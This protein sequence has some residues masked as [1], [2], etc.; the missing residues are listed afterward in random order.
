MRSRSSTN[1]LLKLIDD[2]NL[3]RE[4]FVFFPESF[5]K[6]FF[7]KRNVKGYGYLFEDKNID[8]VTRVLGGKAGAELYLFINSFKSSALLSG[9]NNYSLVK[10]LYDLQKDIFGVFKDF[11]LKKVLENNAKDKIILSD[12][13]ISDYDLFALRTVKNHAEGYAS[14]WGKKRFSCSKHIKLYDL[15]LDAPV[16]VSLFYKREP[17]AVASFFPFDDRTLMINQLQG[18]SPNKYD[19]NK[20]LKGKFKARG[21]AVLDWQKLLVDIVLGVGYDFNYDF[22]AIRG[23]NNHPDA[24]LDDYAS[25]DDLS[26]SRALKMYDGVAKRLGFK[27]DSVGDW[28]AP[29]RKIF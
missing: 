17:A 21:L 16:A 19:E 27:E 11:D 28:Y 4:S 20:I 2:A 25:A 3:S 6:S 18:V 24:F 15:W 10:R 26:F 5:L 1:D 14:H 8:E 9:R 29:A 12:K 22:V 13:K 23:A 7:E